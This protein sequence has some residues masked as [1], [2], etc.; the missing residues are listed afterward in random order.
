MRKILL[1][2]FFLGWL[3]PVNALPVSKNSDTFLET[4]SA[5]YRSYRLDEVTVISNPK[6][7]AKLFE[8]PGSITYLSER[9]IE[10]LNLRSVKDISTVAPNLFIPDYGSKLISS[11]YIRGIGSRINSPA[12]GLNVNNIP[13]LDKSAFD[14]DFLEIDRIEILRGPQ[15]TLYGRNTMAGLINIYTK[16][17]LIIRVRKLCLAE[18]I[19]RLWGCLHLQAGK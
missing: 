9:N 2:L 17:P 14:F 3:L 10:E 15:G 6:A 4:D 11:A 18:V 8:F 13:Y 5:G 1:S 16:S 12:V 7:Y 19:I